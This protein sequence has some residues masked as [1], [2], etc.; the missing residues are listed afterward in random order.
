MLDSHKI[1][2]V[3]S[4]MPSFEGASAGGFDWF[5]S[6]SDAR[7]AL[8]EH[9]TADTGNDWTHD[10]TMRSIPVPRDL[11]NEQIT[12]LLD[13]DLRE[14]RELSLPVEWESFRDLGG[15]AE[16]EPELPTMTRTEYRKRGGWLGVNDSGDTTVTV[17]GTTYRLIE[18]DGTIYRTPPELLGDDNDGEVTP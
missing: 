2:Y 1:V 14:E 9:V 7:E 12:E 16:L 6:E 13:N 15:A 17:D 18:D 4:F 10:Y 11:S 8:I 3:V 5:F